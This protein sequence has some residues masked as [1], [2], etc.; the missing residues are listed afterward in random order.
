[1]LLT[2]FFSIIAVAETYGYCSIK[3]QL[4][5]REDRGQYDDRDYSI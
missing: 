4:A 3:S 5:Y 2:G 1:M